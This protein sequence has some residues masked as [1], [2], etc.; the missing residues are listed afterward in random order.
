[1]FPD[2]IPEKLLWALGLS[3]AVVTMASHAHATSRLSAAATQ[4]VICQPDHC[5]E[6]VTRIHPRLTTNEFLGIKSSSS[7]EAVPV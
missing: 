4:K 3:A 7:V 1:M 5:A 6:T 2:F